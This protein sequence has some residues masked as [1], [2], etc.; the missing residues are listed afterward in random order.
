MIKTYLKI[1]LSI[2]SALNIYFITNHS[3]KTIH[4]N[5]TVLN[6]FLHNSYGQVCPFGIVCGKI[7]LLLSIIQIYF[8]YKNNYGKIKKINL[9]LLIISTILSFMNSYVQKN[10]IP[11]F[12]MQLFIIFL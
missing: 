3:D 2:L 1:L 12:I 7:M 6:F 4:K 10:I 8:L 9:I 11:A 5:I